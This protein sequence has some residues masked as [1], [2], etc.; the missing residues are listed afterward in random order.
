M[1]I[2]NIKFKPKN[3]KIV[4]I[5]EKTKEI[6]TIKNINERIKLNL[7]IENL[8]KNKIIYFRK[9]KYLYLLLPKYSS[10]LRI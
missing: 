3:N 8:S 1:N 5:L 2:N 4:K 7:Y 9:L 6:E 10:A